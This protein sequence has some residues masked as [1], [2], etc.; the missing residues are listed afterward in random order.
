[1]NSERWE[2]VQEVLEGALDLPEAER[3]AFV[4]RS[5]AGDSEL[6]K[7]VRSL[8]TAAAV[9][10]PPTH[11]MVALAAP[12]ED[13]FA[14]GDRVADRYRV[15]RLL[16][17]GGMGEV[18]EAFDEELGITVA[19]KALREVESGAAERLKLEGMLA[20]SVWHPNVCRV[21]ELGRHEE[22]LWFLTM[23]RLEGRTLAHR[24]EMDGAPTREEAL[25]IVEDIA[26]GLG[27]AHRAGV[28]HRDLKPANVM[29]VLRDGVEQAVVTDFGISRVPGARDSG[30]VFGTPEYM[31]PEQRQGEEVGPAADIFALGRVVR[32]LL[33]AEEAVIARCVE[34]DARKRFARAEDVV[35]AL[36]GRA[37]AAVEQV[38][39]WPSERDAF[40]G[41]A[42]DLE[43]LERTLDDARIVTL[44]GPGGMGKTRL[45]IRFGARAPWPGGSWF[46]D[47]TEAKTADGVASAVGGALSVQLG[48]G[49]AIGQ[50]G[51]AIA[52]RGRCLL[53]LD[54]FEQVVR[55]AGETVGRWRQLAPEATFLV[56]S[57]VRLQ[58]EDERA[59]AVEPLSLEEGTELFSLRAHGLRPGLEFSDD[60]ARD[61]VRH[62]DGIPLAI[63]L[64]AARTRV[65]SVGQIAENVRKRF[66][67]LA[68]GS[69]ARHET[70]LGTI[71]ES[72]GLLTPWERAAWA[73][74]AVFEGGC[75][76]DAALS[77]LDVTAWPDAPPVV[78][79]LR[80]LVDQSL[81]RTF[82]PPG[83][84]AVDARFGMYVTLQEYAR[85][86]LA[87]AEPAETR[88]GTHY[89]RY[90]GEEAI[91]A[92][93]RS[94]GPARRRRAV[95][96]LDNLIAAFRRAVARGDGAVAGRGLRA[97]W[98]ILRMRGP[99]ETA[100]ALGQEGLAESRLTGL[101]R[102]NFLFVLGEAEQ[103][104]GTYEESRDHA[105]EAIRIARELGDV[106]LETLTAGVLGR[107]DFALSRHE[108]AEAMLKETLQRCDRSASCAA[109]NA[110]GMMQHEL[111][112]KEEARR[113]YE[114]ALGVARE[115]DDRNQEA[116]VQ[117]SFGI[118]EHKHGNLDAAIALFERALATHL[119]AG[120]RR[121]E[122]VIHVNLG[123]V[124]ADS[125]QWA[126]A[127][128]HIQAAIK[129][130]HEL[131]SRASQATALAIIGELYA[132]LGQLEEARSSLEAA[133]ILHEEIGDRKHFGVN[134]AS[135]ARVRWMKG[136]LDEALAGFQQALA[137]LQ[138]TGY[139]Y[140]E[141]GCLTFLALI[142]LDQREYAEAGRNLDAA[143]AIARELNARHEL[144]R[145]LSVR[146]MVE[147]ECGNTEAARDA[148]REAESYAEGITLP[149][150]SEIGRSLARARA[151]VGSHAKA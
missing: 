147:H 24:L 133:L 141:A 80:S 78:D 40:V 99:L 7:E 68:G 60:E 138:E 100:I 20:R 76:L 74:C 52:G 146:A 35:D 72:F 39:A 37:P 26:G 112:N 66:Q 115:I 148:M 97:A 55:H 142:R 14:P 30:V 140:F 121:S 126:P 92:L 75:T 11:W 86:K 83:A 5:C 13:R 70:L 93:D 108:E 29:L 102:A 87:D 88:H 19:L 132:D 79:I 54:N 10:S 89:A 65:M 8:L 114:E 49:D 67:L 47:L 151:M 96:E 113:F 34:D 111:G 28:V 3:D 2:R 137:I 125:G 16:G 117:T 50:L 139:R 144:A 94:D 1:M 25:R 48:R 6:E 73:Q 46:C 84:S 82:V 85:L 33:P 23:E 32:E 61:I 136:E 69:G 53:V 63:E 123:S 98:A 77:V 9:D 21:Y 130:S 51:H 18:Y 122:G 150:D 58:L 59:I 41:R 119:E 131:G 104:S 45:A 116:I 129:I 105:W 57:R 106:R 127:L 149:P 36:H 12:E 38:S 22:S 4:E 128:E 27:A 120:N 107:A 15:E 71:D 81:L 124:Y 64:A 62:L 17:R 134:L 145:I 42:S 118:L 43:D 91:A 101:D 135:L 110:Y 103:F 143:Q 31:A 56:T 90:G 109:L 44:V 95:R